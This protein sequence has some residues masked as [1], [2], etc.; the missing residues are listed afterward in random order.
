MLN[1]TFSRQNAVAQV[2]FFSGLKGA[3][4]SYEFGQIKWLCCHYWLKIKKK[5][6]RRE[7][8]IF[9]NLIDFYTPFLLFAN[10]TPIPSVSIKAEQK[11]C[12]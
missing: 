3:A 2:G 12:S 4:F 6:I 8:Y 10:W 11:C 1:R 5:K 7:T 9:I